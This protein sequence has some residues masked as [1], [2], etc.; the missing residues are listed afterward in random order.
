[1]LRGIFL[2]IVFTFSAAPVF[3]QVTLGIKV[4][5]TF[6]TNRIKSTS[7]TT[8]INSDG[9]AL[10]FAIGPIA[11]YEFRENYFVSTGLLFVAKRVGIEAVSDQRTITEE[12]DLQYLQVP[13]TIKLF[14]N[15]VALDKKIYFQLGGTLEF[16]INEPQKNQDNLL[17]QDFLI[18]DSSLLAGMGMEYKVGV[19]TILF[20]G[21]TYQRGLVNSVNKKAPLDGDL[22]VKND[23]FGIDFGVKF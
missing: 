2:F 21:I 19:N 3:S 1:M 8:S 23:Y 9:A 10:R 16:N 14:T 6:S 20:G 11:D 15:E 22:S 12:Y 7:D 17:I 5:P 13:L 18:F 4:S